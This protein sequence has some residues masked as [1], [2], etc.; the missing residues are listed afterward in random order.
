M[1]EEYECP[2]QNASPP[3]WKAKE[4]ALPQGLRLNMLQ[5]FGARIILNTRALPISVCGTRRNLSRLLRSRLHF[6]LAYTHRN[7]YVP[8]LWIALK[9]SATGR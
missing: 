4:T 7:V 6:P 5:R 8:K 1:S 3:Y 9:E 2:C